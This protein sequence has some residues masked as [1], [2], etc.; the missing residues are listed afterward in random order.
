MKVYLPSTKKDN[1]PKELKEKWTFSAF[2][3]KRNIKL[4]YIKVNVPY[5]IWSIAEC[6]TGRIMIHNVGSMSKQAFMEISSFIIKYAS[7]KIE[8]AIEAWEK[9]E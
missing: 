2:G 7:E 3:N 8:R 5:K 9:K 1:P 4:A 6:S